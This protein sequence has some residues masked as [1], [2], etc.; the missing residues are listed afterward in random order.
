[1]ANSGLLAASF[2]GTGRMPVEQ[3]ICPKKGEYANR[4][5][6]PIAKIRLIWALFEKGPKLGSDGTPGRV[7]RAQTGAGLAML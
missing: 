5:F 4:L 6:R 2:F 3:E 7:I 1:M